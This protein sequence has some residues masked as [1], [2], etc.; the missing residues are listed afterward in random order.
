MSRKRK[1]LT[2]EER[3]SVFKKVGDGKSC[4]SIA[5]ELDVGKI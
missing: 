2:L 3:D 5:L 4:R 1:I